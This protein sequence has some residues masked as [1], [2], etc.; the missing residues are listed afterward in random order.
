MISW[1]QNV[2]PFAQ[3]WLEAAASLMTIGAFFLFL[4][5]RLSRVEGKVDMLMRMMEKRR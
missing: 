2:L 5:R 4:E 1:I 3:S